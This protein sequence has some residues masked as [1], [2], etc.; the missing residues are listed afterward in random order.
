MEFGND[1]PLVKRLTKLAARAAGAIRPTIGKKERWAW[2][3]SQVRNALT[4]LNADS[5]EFNGGDLVFLTES[6]YA[7]VR[8][9]MLLDCGVA[10]DTLTQKADSDTVYW[11]RSR[12]AQ[13]IERVREQLRLVKPDSAQAS[14]HLVS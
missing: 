11:Y 10:I 5:P 12:L 6:V 7:V 9:C 13:S 3:L 4:H 2:T 1:P 8:I 14:A